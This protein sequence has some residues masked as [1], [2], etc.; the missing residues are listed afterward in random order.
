MKLIL[1]TDPDQPNDEI[2][3]LVHLLDQGVYRL[4]IRKPDWTINQVEKLLFQIPEIHYPKISLHQ[5]HQLTFSMKLGGNH[6]K[7]NQKVIT[8]PGKISSKSFHHLGNLMET[9][10]QGLDYAFLSPVFDSISK[11]GYHQNFNPLDLKLWIRKNKAKIPFSLIALGGIIPQKV[12]MV[13]EM[14][15]DGIAVL[16][17]IWKLKTK[18]ERVNTFREFIN[19]IQNE[20]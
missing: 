6:F 9:P 4:H 17:A 13:N 14:G 3:T 1:I 16:G 11:N 20:V 15:F 5:Y 12:A 19:Y 7:S 2:S 8:S 10:Y 18:N